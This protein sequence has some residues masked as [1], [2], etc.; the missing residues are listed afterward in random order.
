MIFKPS[1]KQRL[2]LF[3][4]KIF[5][6]SKS[7]KVEAIN[8]TA[9]L[10]QNNYIWL[11]FTHVGFESGNTKDDIYQFCLEKFPTFKEITINSEVG[12]IK[13]TLSAMD[14][15]QKSKFIDDAV[16]FFRSEGFEVPSC[17]DKKIDEMYSYYRNLGMI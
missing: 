15:L 13:V 1:E 2:I 16:I 9:T 3:V 14:K 12:L 6:K 11:V 7:V 8:K 4:D 17:E 5:E 10:S